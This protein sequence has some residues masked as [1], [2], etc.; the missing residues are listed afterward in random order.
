[1]KP[2][3]NFSFFAAYQPDWIV[4]VVKSDPTMASKFLYTVG[5]AT[6]IGPMGFSAILA[7]LGTILYAFG[8]VRFFYAVISP[9]LSRRESATARSNNVAR[10]YTSNDNAGQLA[11]AL[12][13][14]SQDEPFT[15][16][17]PMPDSPIAPPTSLPG[18]ACFEWMVKW[19]SSLEVPR[20]G[21]GHG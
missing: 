8:T 15:L 12:A 18:S 20:A 17:D 5:E 19:P 16:E 10:E 9:L 21:L 1:M 3:M 6:H 4:Q 2:L 14:F 7:L 13:D 11:L